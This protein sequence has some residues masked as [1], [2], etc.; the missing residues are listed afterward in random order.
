[1]GLMHYFMALGPYGCLVT[2]GA[3]F[4][5]TSLVVAGLILRGE[6]LRAIRRSRVLQL[7]ALT[8]LSLGFFI[9]LDAQIVFGLALAWFFG[10]W[11]G[12]LLTLEITWRLRFKE[13]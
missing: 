10:A 8:L 6:E 1:M 3:F 7:G 4:M 2:C 5:G 11:V 12:S 13:I 9:M